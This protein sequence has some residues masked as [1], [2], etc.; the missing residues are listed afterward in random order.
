MKK[1]MGWGNVSKLYHWWQ[2]FQWCPFV[3]KSHH[4]DRDIVIV[5]FSEGTTAALCFSV[6]QYR[7]KF[8]LYSY[9]GTYLCKGTAC[10]LFANDNCRMRVALLNPFF[11]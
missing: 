2:K 3:W 7:Q 8:A 6:L 11:K 4:G 10:R 9:A 5:S 1:V